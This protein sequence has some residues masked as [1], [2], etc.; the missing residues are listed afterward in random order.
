MHRGEQRRTR[1]PVHVED[2]AAQGGV[3]PEG[4]LAE[5][6]RFVEGVGEHARRRLDVAEP[7][8]LEIARHAG[9]VVFRED[10]ELPRLDQLR[11]A[12]RAPRRIVKTHDL[13]PSILVL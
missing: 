2:I 8:A 1:A 6:A 12:H 11:P 13:H 7:P 3:P 4:R 9:H 5:A 10:G